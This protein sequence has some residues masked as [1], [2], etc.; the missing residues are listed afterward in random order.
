M[1]ATDHK[2]I[3]YG[4]SSRHLYGYLENGVYHSGRTKA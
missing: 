3:D 4:N 1:R 2:E